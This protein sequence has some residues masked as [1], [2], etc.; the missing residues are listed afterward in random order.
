[1]KI[2]I[3][4]DRPGKWWLSIVRHGKEWHMPLVTLPDCPVHYSDPYAYP[5]EHCPVCGDEWGISWL[6]WLEIKLWWP[7]LEWWHSDPHGPG[8]RWWWWVNGPTV[9]YADTLDDWTW[10]SR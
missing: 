7:V 5:S 3:G 1:M 4:P 9:D 2:Y 6:R 10:E 8:W